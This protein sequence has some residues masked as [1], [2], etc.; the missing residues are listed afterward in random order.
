M[1]MS[2]H[3]CL[4]RM[5]QCVAVDPCEHVCVHVCVCVCTFMYHS[6]SFG[7][8]AHVFVCVCVCVVCVFARECVRTGVGLAGR[9]PPRWARSTF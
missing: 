5:S 1:R 8:C 3:V 7:P 4:V 9:W 2:E 6:V